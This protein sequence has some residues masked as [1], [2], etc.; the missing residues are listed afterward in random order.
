MTAHERIKDFL[1]RVVPWPSDQT[2]GYVNLHWRSK[3]SRDPTK[4]FW[5]GKPFKNVTALIDTAAWALGRENIQDIYFCTSLQAKAGKNT[6]GGLKVMRSKELAVSLK[7]IWLDVD[8]K[9]PP[10]GYTT[11][12]D[13]LTAVA[14]FVKAAGLV[15]PSALVA[16]GGGLHIYWISNR[17][18]SVAEWQPYA[19]GLKTLAVKHKLLCDAGVTTDAARILRVPGTFNFKLDVPRPVRVLGLKPME[20]D[21][22]FHASLSHICGLVGTHKPVSMGTVLRGKPAAVF[23]SVGDSLT[24]GIERDETPLPWE[25]LV[26]ECGFFR[27]ALKTG[28]KDYSQPMWNLSTLMAT[29]L[30]DGHALSHRMGKSHPGYSSETTDALWDRKVRERHDRGLGWPSCTAIQ[31]SGCGSCA[32]CPH[33]AKGKSPLH[34]IL[35][36]GSL[37]S[38][39]GEVEPS[40]SVEPAVEDD[41]HLPIGYIL[42]EAGYICKLEPAKGKAGEAGETVPH[43]LFLNRI[44][45]P[46]VE[47]SPTKALSFTVATDKG[48][49]ERVTLPA[50]NIYNGGEMWK[51][52]QD[53]GLLPDTTQRANGEGLLM[54]WLSK[55]QDAKA[56][57][58]ASPFGW[59]RNDGKREGFVYGG[60]IMKSDGTEQPSGAGDRVLRTQYTPVGKVEPWFDAFKVIADQHRPELEAIV[61]ASFAAPLMVTPAEYSCMLACWGE[62]G[63][64]KSSAVKVGL[65][66]WGHPKI[67]KA[68]TK[69]TSRSAIHQMGETK[70]LPMYW[71]EIQEET[72]Q[73]LYEVFFD[74]TLG[75]GPGRLTSDVTQRTKGDWQTM[76]V[77]TSNY[78]FVDFLINKQKSTGAG[79]Y[80]VFEYEVSK[81]PPGAPGMINE[82]DASRTMQELEGNFGVMG[83]KYAKMLGSDPKGIDDFTKNICDKFRE[84][85]KATPSER[86]WTATCGTLIAGAELANLVGAKFDVPTLHK[87]LVVQYLK[88]RARHMSE[89]NEGGTEV[90]AE[91]HLSNFLRDHLSNAIYTDTFPK[92]S[93]QPAPVKVFSGP[94]IDKGESIYVQ[95]AITDKVLRFSR[96]E[97]RKYLAAQ[98]VPPTSV[99]RGLTT[100]YKMT[101]RRATLGAGTP[102]VVLQANLIEIPVEDGSPLHEL[103]MAHKPTLDSAPL[104]TSLQTLPQPQAA[105]STAQ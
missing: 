10:K 17:P 21:Y 33:F 81:P 76:M 40:G 4:V 32:T 89:A 72:L 97:F 58:H 71:D 22:D 104:G 103:M 66:V 70:N 41:L 88:N 80:R 25:P 74:A 2:D 9:D 54:S 69:T 27:E 1:S 91:E 23:A 6:K 37:R 31:A 8:V 56:A 39:S 18:L 36:E 53:Q 52:L 75:V 94:R 96:S 20:N 29:F 19:E 92:G 46:V 12:D 98:K 105:T 5:G 79:I 26:K 15:P 49:Y 100:H 78:N 85:V 14:T 101:E 64:F 38:R 35:A 42:N 43:Q 95:W 44:S 11:L 62:T 67:T 77:T 61:A 102:W 65:A 82:M 57:I 93:G 30:E 90:H 16:T 59:W 73:N 7:A 50:K 86:Y 34:T 68:V 48:N 87:W 13:A 84:E 55:L 45:S 24:E 28:G 63:S 47:A 51:I 60:K 83:L 99:M 3:D